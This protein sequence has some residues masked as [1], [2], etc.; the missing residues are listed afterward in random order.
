MEKTPEK[1]SLMAS[2]CNA[3]SF[4]EYSPKTHNDI[5][6]VTFY[7][8][9]SD[10]PATAKKAVSFPHFDHQSTYVP[11]TNSSNAMLDQI[12]LSFPK[13]Q[14]EQSITALQSDQLLEEYL[15]DAAVKVSD[16]E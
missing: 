6:K 16:E 5:I 10:D 2:F 15:Y 4:K 8:D 13:G 7:I 14:E 3:L 11:G 12:R 9:L 1:C